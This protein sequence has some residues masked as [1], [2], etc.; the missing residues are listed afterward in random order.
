MLTLLVSSVLEFRSVVGLLKLRVQ[1]ELQI[2]N[3]RG[4]DQSLVVGLEGV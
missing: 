2:K 1:L 4:N 3:L